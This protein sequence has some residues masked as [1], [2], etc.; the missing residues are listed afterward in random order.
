MCEICLKDFP[1]EMIQTY[2]N[3]NKSVFVPTLESRVNID[4]YAAKI[5]ANAVQ[6]WAFEGTEIAGFMACYFNHPGR[7]FGFI[8]TISIAKN[9]QG[10]GIGKRMI[11]S[12][13]DYATKT[14]FLKLRLEVNKFNLK[15]I[16]LYKKMGFL[17]VGSNGKDNRYM[18]LKTIKQSIKM[19]HLN[20]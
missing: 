10:K 14:G 17:D 16:Q 15:A 7:G 2:F 19:V 1:K 20:K 18:E 8:T 6:F 12:A 13:I 11:Q 9:H 4:D 5:A 3:E